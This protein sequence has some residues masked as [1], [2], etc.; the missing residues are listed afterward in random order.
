MF[1]DGVDRKTLRNS[2]LIKQ[3]TNF[4]MIIAVLFALLILVRNQNLGTDKF[5]T[6]QG[7]DSSYSLYGAGFTD[8]TIKLWGYR[9][10]SVVIIVSIYMAIKSFREGKTKKLI[11]NLAIVP[12]YL[13]VVF[14]ALILFQA[15]FVTGN[16]VKLSYT[17]R[18]TMIEVVISKK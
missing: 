7:A 18:T 16:D 17:S 6:L 2:K 14:I 5:L 1:F 11:L 10:L 15:V 9:L 12:A 13:V 4:I 3:I 8:V